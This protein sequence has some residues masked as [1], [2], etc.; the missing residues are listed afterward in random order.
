[1]IVTF[2]KGT[3]TYALTEILKHLGEEKFEKFH[4]WLQN[5]EVILFTNGRYVFATDWERWL[6]ENE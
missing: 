5:R 6:K 3:K 4:E 2:I 1:M